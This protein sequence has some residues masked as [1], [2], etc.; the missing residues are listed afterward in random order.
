MGQ[1]ETPAE[2]AGA[3]YTGTL[4]SQAHKLKAELIR[5][6]IEDLESWR[7][8]LEKEWT[9]AHPDLAG[10]P[11]VIVHDGFYQEPSQVGG[12]PT[13]TRIP[14]AEMEGYRN[15][16]R[17]EYYEWVVPAFEQFREPDPDALNPMIDNMRQI[18]SWFGG[19]QDEARP[20]SGSTQRSAIARIDSVR[21]DMEEWKGTFQIN[22]LD[23]FVNPLQTVSHNMSGVAKGTHDGL[24]LA[25][26]VYVRQRLEV[27]KLLD[28]S[29]KAVQ[30]LNN[31]RDPE[32]H[33]W[34]TLIGI[35][36]GTILTAASG[37][38]MWI[39]IAL[40]VTSTISQGFTPDPAAQFEV[41]APT[42]QEVAL[43]VSQ[44]LG[45]ISSKTAGDEHKVQ[46]MFHQMWGELST[47]RSASM[48]SNT[49]GPYVV[50]RP[51]I[52][53]AK[54]GDFNDNTLAPDR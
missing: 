43:K 32:A 40:I 2:V 10:K 31:A 48:S 39:G 28:T 7:N 18:E 12:A 33:T 34:A 19:S 45:R 17:N 8:A 25:K 38:V 42:A 11:G 13:L 5:Q 47:S 54:A 29:I 52:S 9:A 26:S 3:A 6:T 35:S 41:S 16:I 53:T 51:D 4:M 15:Q 1:V 21:G 23:N 36:V 37:P 27:L 50:P 24:E 46:T 22:F 30:A 49:E 44:A 20:G 14:E